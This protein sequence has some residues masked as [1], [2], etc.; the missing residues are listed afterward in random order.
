MQPV[1]FVQ[2]GIEFV[3]VDAFAPCYG[4]TQPGRFIE[5]TIRQHIILACH[6]FTQIKKPLN[7]V[8]AVGTIPEIQFAEF[9]AGIQLNQF[10]KLL[11][12]Q[13][14]GAQ[15]N[16]MIFTNAQAF[17]RHVAQLLPHH[18]A[19]LAFIFG[20]T[21]GK[22]AFIAVRVAVNSIQ[23]FHLQIIQVDGR[24]PPQMIRAPGRHRHVQRER[25]DRTLVGVQ[26]AHAL[27]VNQVFHAVGTKFPGSRQRTFGQNIAKPLTKG[28]LF[29]QFDYRF[30]IAPFQ[31]QAPGILVGQDTLL[32]KFHGPA[33]HAADLQGIKS[34][35]VDQVV[36]DKN[37]FHAAAP[38]FGTEGTLTDI[39]RTVGIGSGVLTAVDH[40][41]VPAV[42]LAAK[43]GVHSDGVFIEIFGF[44]VLTVRKL[45]VLKITGAYQAGGIA[46]AEDKV[47]A[48]ALHVLGGFGG[49]NLIDDFFV[50][51]QG[52]LGLTD[53]NFQGSAAGNGF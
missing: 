2:H 38:H 32:V 6:A 13:M 51:F 21:V 47:G 45:I 33:D 9:Q 22:G 37:R 35:I 29:D 27:H 19:G 40:I 49:N 16:R 48:P 28:N 23:H 50:V 5:I 3:A 10:G 17:H 39:I 34:V 25:R 30:S 11:K 20:I 8:A 43:T 41:P 42:D 1:I 52:F 15:K 44:E 12:R 18:H 53:L 14:V 46:D 26:V 24:P 4:Q 36:G 31:F 7:R